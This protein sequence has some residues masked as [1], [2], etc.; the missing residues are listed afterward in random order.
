MSI[1]QGVATTVKFLDR[2]N[3]LNISYSVRI[4][5]YPAYKFLTLGPP[6]ARLRY[7]YTGKLT[8]QLIL[9]IASLFSNLC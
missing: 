2:D 9:R 8:E 4:A 3:I 7:V 1:A 5:G 6:R